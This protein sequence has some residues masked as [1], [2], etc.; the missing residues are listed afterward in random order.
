MESSVLMRPKLTTRLLAALLAACA[1][2]L[3]G[4]PG[5]N[6]GPLLLAEPTGFQLLDLGPF[7]PGET[8]GAAVYGLEPEGEQGLAVGAAEARGGTRGFVS[9]GRRIRPLV[10]LDG[11]GS[12]PR[13]IEL[14]Q[15]AELAAG[16][17]LDLS[18]Q[19]R[20]TLWAA[21][22]PMDLGT[23]G[24]ALGYAYDVRDG[25]VVGATLTSDPGQ[26]VHATLWKDG[27][28]QDLG[29][30]PG[31][32]QSLAFSVDS[33]LVAGESIT[34]QD[35]VASIHAVLWANGQIRELGTLGGPHST[36]LGVA[37]FKGPVIQILDADT[38]V[39]GAADVAP[40]SEHAFLWQGGVMQD[41]GTLGGLNSR[42]TA[43]NRS[44]W[45]VG[46]SDVPGDPAQ[47]GF[48]Y[49]GG[50]MRNLNTMLKGKAKRWSV[51]SALDV[52]ETGRIGG[53]AI[54]AAGEERAV[55]LIPKGKIRRR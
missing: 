52:D 45:I 34:R 31:G 44:G 30:L 2:W 21:G 22:N 7:R 13:S 29:V 54:N 9:A 40:G 28:P 16:S 14:H 49:V 11:G 41:L 43:V 42:A 53:S 37:R 48:L 35:G 27:E 26:G 38:L 3:P 20:P 55:V 24:G 46:V 6:A 47:V 32:G 18:G 17:S 25:V 33:G 39:V 51:V 5:A 19:I 23:L 36:A 10:G 50:I 4:A 8:S 12:E 1:A 15:G